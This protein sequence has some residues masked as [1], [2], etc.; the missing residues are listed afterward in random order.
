MV[1][2]VDRAITEP[3]PVAKEREGR[4]DYNDQLD[5]QNGQSS[6]RKRTEEESEI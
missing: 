3:S 4:A 6:R 1:L 5:E 2:H